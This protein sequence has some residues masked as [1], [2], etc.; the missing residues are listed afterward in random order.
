MAG[1]RPLARARFRADERGMSTFDPEAY[2]RQA[3]AAV[4]LPL[5]DRH[6]PGVVMNLA[7]AARMAGLVAQMPLIPADEAAPVFVAA[8]PLPK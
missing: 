7:L 4:G 3:A 1:R 8:R 6:L 5:H 2:A